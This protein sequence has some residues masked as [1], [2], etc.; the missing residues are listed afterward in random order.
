MDQD[1]VIILRILICSDHLVV[2]FI[3][4]HIVFQP[5]VAKLQEEFLRPARHLRLQRELQVEHIFPHRAGQRFLKYIKIF[6]RLF[7][8]KR[9]ESLF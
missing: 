6:E 4:K 9:Q 8:R 7:L 3:Q 1:N 5:A 2:K